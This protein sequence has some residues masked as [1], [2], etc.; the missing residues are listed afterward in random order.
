MNAV[1]PGENSALALP[2]A[3]VRWVCGRSLTAVAVL[4]CNG[5]WDL[6]KEGR[7]EKQGVNLARDTGRQQFKN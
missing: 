7:L 1:G 6:L 2:Q 4:F 3:R 5:N